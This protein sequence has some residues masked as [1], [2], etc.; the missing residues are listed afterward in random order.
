MVG[1]IDYSPMHLSLEEVNVC[2]GHK[3]LMEVDDKVSN[4]WQSTQDF[5]PPTQALPNSLIK[6]YYINYLLYY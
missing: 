5:M 6:Y 4:C 3:V 2:A 1:Q